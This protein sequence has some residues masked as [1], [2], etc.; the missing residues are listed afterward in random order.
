MKKNKQNLR[1]MWDTIKHTNKHIIRVPEG[2]EG[3]KRKE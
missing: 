1:E 3:E 2:E